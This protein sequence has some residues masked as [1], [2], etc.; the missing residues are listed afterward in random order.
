MWSYVRAAF[1]ISGLRLD[2][3]QTG[4]W[5][6][7][8]LLAPRRNGICMPVDSSLSVVGLQLALMRPKACF[9]NG[10]WSD[11]ADFQVGCGLGAV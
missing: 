6:N 3:G 2:H 7:Q 4:N 11:F 1:T 5:A 8:S 9:P 10:G